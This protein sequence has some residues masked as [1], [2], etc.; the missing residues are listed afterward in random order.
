MQ[1]DQT[2]K[3]QTERPDDHTMTSTGARPARCEQCD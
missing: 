3:Q 1:I 2:V